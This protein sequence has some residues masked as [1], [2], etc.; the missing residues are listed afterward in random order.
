[1]IKLNKQPTVLDVYVRVR[2][3]VI[4]RRKTNKQTNNSKIKIKRI[5]S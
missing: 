2:V 1:M 3:R 4:V 5:L